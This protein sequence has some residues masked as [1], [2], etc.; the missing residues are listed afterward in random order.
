[1]SEAF[2]QISFGEPSKQIIKVIIDEDGIAHVTHEVQGNREA[3]QQVET[4]V[5][6]MSNLSVVDKNASEVQYLTL[7]KYPIA[8]VLPPSSYETIFIKYDLSN[9]LV[10]KDGVWTWNWVGIEPTNFYFPQN[11][12]MIWINDNPIYTGGKG[13]RQH[14][15]EMTL[16]YILNEPVIFKEI[17]W[18]DKKFQVGI[19]T[20][21]D[22]DGFEFN[23]KEKRITFDMT[24]D[25][26]LVTAIIPLEL[27]WEPYDVYFNGNQTRNSEFNNNG[28]YAWVGFSPD[29]S[30]TIDIIG[31]TVIPE[32]PL[33][34]PLA[35]GIFMVLML[36]FKN[37]FSFR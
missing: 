31:T 7:E 33:F 36:S 23:Q 6:T 10:L 9:V 15:G 4:I 32:F 25:N 24:K 27:L 1:M 14:G 21:A 37:R 18:E 28:T 16:E 2:G 12:D 19:R 17:T 26:S 34:L 3:T 5:G 11:V 30:G 22:I 8:I 35:I 20:L 13:I 29:T